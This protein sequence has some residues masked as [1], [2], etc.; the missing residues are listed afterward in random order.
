[1]RVD[2]S[3]VIDNSRLGGFQ[4]LVVVLCGMVMII[5]GF[6][7]VSMGMVVPSLSAD[8]GIPASAFSGALSAALV[9]VLFGSAAAG[10]MGDII[11]RRW[12][13]I[14]MLLIAAVFM[15]LTATADSIA[16]I[17]VYRFFTGFGAGGSIPVAIALTSEYMPAARRNML[18]ALMYAG[19]A[20]GSVIGGF[21]GPALIDAFGWQGIFYL[22]A[23]LT[24]LAAILLALAL[25]ESIR[26]LVAKRTESARALKLLKRIVPGFDVRP[27]TELV[28]EEDTHR[29][30]AVR[31]LF[32]GR[33]TA[34]TL[35]VWLIFFGNQFTIFFVGLWLPTVF[36][37]GGLD[38]KAA[39]FVLAIYN[40]GG[41]IGGP[42][43][44]WFSDRRTAQQVL[45][46]AYPMAAVAIAAI[47]LTL[48]FK[49]LLGPVTFIAGAAAL[50]AS[51]CL[52]AL[53]ASLYP[54]RARSTGVGWAL[55]VGRAGSIIAPFIGGIVL[56]W[57]TKGFFLTA[58]LAPL[59]CAIG[60][61]MLIPLT[62]ESASQAGSATQ[63][64][65]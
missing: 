62:R 17:L 27:E 53:T 31:E 16:E 25:P 40:L 43:L 57:G 38:I 37:E 13:L 63:G 50:G 10:S 54:T 29:G 18:V 32:G 36:V 30:A 42:V 34:V 26:F 44:G 45:M 21:S 20:V 64:N 11:G 15:G 24:G 9:G 47:G 52:G 46:V 23:I 1:M 48:E 14:L 8:W 51:L 22:G 59:I 6:D 58:A 7:I 5:D 4:I 56:T 28:V 33:Q 3:N 35:V 60:M 65:A 49:A 41:A 12:T 2:V 55:S 61:A 39:L 19:A